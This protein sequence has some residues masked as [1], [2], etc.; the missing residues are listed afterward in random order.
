MIVLL[1]L[2][3]CHWWGGGGG[4]SELG[5]RQV[6]SK[7]R[8]YFITKYMPTKLMQSCPGTH[9]RMCVCVCASVRAC[10]FSVHTQLQQ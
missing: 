7:V 6:G 10:V 5:G 1:L 8:F 9:A 2:L 3:V 4:G